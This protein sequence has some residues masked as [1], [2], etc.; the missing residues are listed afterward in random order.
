MPL[1]QL[2]QRRICISTLF[3]L[4]LAPTTTTTR[5]SCAYDLLEPN[6]GASIRSS[7]RRA[8]AMTQKCLSVSL[9]TKRHID[10]RERLQR[11]NACAPHANAAYKACAPHANA[12]NASHRHILRHA[13]VIKMQRTAVMSRTGLV[14]VKMSDCFSHVVNTVAVKEVRS[15]LRGQYSLFFQKGF[16]TKPPR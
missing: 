3:Q 1:F 5:T 13:T 10:T 8:N 11:F 14:G 2:R 7:A 15:Q 9:S 16:A 6:E 4:R 12:C